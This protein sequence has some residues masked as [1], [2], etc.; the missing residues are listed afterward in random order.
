MSRDQLLADAMRLEDKAP[1]AN[2][3]LWVIGATTID[4]REQLLIVEAVT[5][6]GAVAVANTLELICG[7]PENK[8]GTLRLSGPHPRDSWP[9]KWWYQWLG[10]EQVGQMEAEILGE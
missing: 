6:P 8:A 3:E 7:D 1:E 10:D 4:G 9:E 5:G 2:K